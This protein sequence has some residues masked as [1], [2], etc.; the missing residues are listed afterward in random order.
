MKI[1]NLEIV[2][3]IHGNVLYRGRFESRN[4]GAFFI[5][6]FSVTEYFESKVIDHQALVV[7]DES[8]KPIRFEENEQ[9]R[10]KYKIYECIHNHLLGSE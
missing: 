1:V 5:A 2:N 3:E 4:A 6:T 7:E 10:A 9:E 8:G